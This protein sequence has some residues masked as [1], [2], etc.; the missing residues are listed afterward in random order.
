[1]FVT[2]PDIAYL[3]GCC[4]PIRMLLTYPDVAY[5]SGCVLVAGSSSPLCGRDR[6]WRGLGREDGRRHGS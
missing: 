2:Y 1:M 5:L 4:L 3:S 6:A